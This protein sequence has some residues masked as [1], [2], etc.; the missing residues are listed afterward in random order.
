MPAAPVE[1]TDCGT[2]EGFAASE[3]DLA[4]PLPELTDR[5]GV[6]LLCHAVGRFVAKLREKPDDNRALLNQ[7]FCTGRACYT[8]YKGNIYKCPDVTFVK[9]INEAGGTHL[10]CDDCISVEDAVN[11]PIE[12]LEKLQEPIDMCRYCDCADFRPF[13]WERV[14][15]K[16][17]I[18]DWFVPD[19]PIARNFV[20]V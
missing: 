4:L 12:T 19:E 10:R 17:N 18:K 9:Y 14:T 5:Y 20:V 7:T 13:P 6:E 1:G 2:V 8:L 16:P 11:S 3:T 15:G